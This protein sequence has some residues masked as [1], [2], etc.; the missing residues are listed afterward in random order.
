MAIKGEIYWYDPDPRAIL[1]LE[2]F[3]ISHSLRRTLKRVAVQEAGGEMRPFWH[4][5][6]SPPPPHHPPEPHWHITTN[7]DF[8]A[9][10]AACADPR[11]PGAWIDERILTAYTSLHELGFAHSVEV[12]QAGQLVG[13]LYGIALQGLFAGEAMFSLASNASKIALAYLVQRLQQK[14]FMLLDVQFHTKHL[15][16]FGVIEIPR[17]QYRQRLRLAMMQERTF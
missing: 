6:V 1:P 11:R 4:T 3:H 17:F 15:A 7:Q 12:W 5:A 16:Q 10:I 2:K 9:V 14:Q 8:P 13:G